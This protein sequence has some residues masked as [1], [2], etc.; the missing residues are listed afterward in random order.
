PDLHLSRCQ[1]SGPNNLHSYPRAFRRLHKLTKATVAPTGTLEP[2]I[3]LII[4]AVFQNSRARTG[5]V[6]ESF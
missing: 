1:W 4:R 6:P 3:I 5:F 2:V